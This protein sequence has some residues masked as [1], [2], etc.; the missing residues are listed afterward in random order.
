MIVLQLF[1]WFSKKTIV[2]VYGFLFFFKYC[3]YYI[4]NVNEN[5]GAG[6]IGS[7][8]SILVFAVVDWV[9]FRFYP[10]QAGIF[11]GVQGRSHSDK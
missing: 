9:T 5:I 7:G 4:C 2:L 1:N 3:G 8:V 6:Y 11:V 10:M